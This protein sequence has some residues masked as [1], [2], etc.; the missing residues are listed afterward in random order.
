MPNDWTDAQE[1]ALILGIGTYGIGW[2]MDR[3]G[4][5]TAG[6]VMVKANSLLGRG[7]LSRGAFSLRRACRES[8]YTPI[9]LRRAMKALG[10]KWKRLSPNGPYL[11]YEDQYEELLDWLGVDYWCAKHRLYNC[12][13]CHKKSKEHRGRGLC[14]RCYRRYAKRLYRAGLSLDQGVLRKVVQENVSVVELRELI[15]SQLGKGR[16]LPEF[17]VERLEGVR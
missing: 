7:G 5:R 16:A 11:I 1:R 10:Q 6:S 13:W 9:Q 3:C 17:F 2:F 4:G 12:L 15:L 14:Q 8:G